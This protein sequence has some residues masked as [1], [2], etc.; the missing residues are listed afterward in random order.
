MLLTATFIRWALSDVAPNLTFVTYYPAILICSL[1]TGWRYGLACAVISG[2]IAEGIFR[3]PAASSSFE[4]GSLARLILFT[5]SC[6]I[7]IATAD[8]L[9]RAVRDLDV[10]NRSA[11]TLNHELQHRVANMLTVVQAL[12]AQS[13]K[14]ASPEQFVAAFGGR[15]QALAKAHELLGQRNLETCTLP[16]LIDEACKPFSAGE[17]I[18]KFG[19]ACQLPSVC[20]VPLVLALHELCTNALKYGALSNPEGKVEISWAFGE[21]PGRL[22]IRWQET[23]GPLVRKPTRKG[24]GSALLRPQPGIAEVNLRFDETGVRCEIDIDGAEPVTNADWQTSSAFAAPTAIHSRIIRRRKH[25][26]CDC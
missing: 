23:R 15:L 6:A 4:A 16:A 10:A 26:P 14:G 21:T 7:I 11:D 19:P 2:V 20:C 8:T 12:A 25:N 24:L 22:A 1:L 3:I 13:A 5:T 9:R 17:N 18:V